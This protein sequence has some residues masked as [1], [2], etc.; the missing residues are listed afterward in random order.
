M[1]NTFPVCCVRGSRLYGANLAHA[2]LTKADLKGSDLKGMMDF[3][4]VDLTGADMRAVD[5]D[6]MVNF[7]GAILHDVDFTGSTTDKILLNFNGADIQNIK[8]IQV[9]ISSRQSQGQEEQEQTT[10]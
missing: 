5:L 7:Y 9:P 10:D 3:T 1:N 4:G 2:N 8:G 6:G